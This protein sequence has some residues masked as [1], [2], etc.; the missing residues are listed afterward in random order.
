MLAS[1]SDA[2]SFVNS[3]AARSA[4]SIALMDDDSLDAVTRAEEARALR[5]LFEKQPLGQAAF[6]KRFEIGNQSMVSQYL[7]GRRPLN[8]KAAA[9]FARGLRVPI[10]D[11]SPR[12]AGLAVSAQRAGAAGS[13]KTPAGTFE[14]TPSEWGH[15]QELR[16]AGDA[17]REFVIEETHRR[18]AE[19][20]KLRTEILRDAGI[21]AN[22][23]SNLGNVIA[24]APRGTQAAPVV[25]VK[26]IADATPAPKPQA[27]RY[28][29]TNKRKSPVT[30]EVEQKAKK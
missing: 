8:L 29:A 30:A 28:V 11:F 4:I 22:P 2:A 21:H 19:H 14:I 9:N 7:T 1:I 5:G 18:Y 12:L 16:D 3:V 23:K 17:N 24:H 26:V 6:G 20:Q 13:A 10:S 25:L 27:S 15:L